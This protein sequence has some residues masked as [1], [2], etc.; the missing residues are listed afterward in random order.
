MDTK[1]MTGA[2]MF[3]RLLGSM[4][5]EKIFASSGSEWSP[6]WE[7]LAKPP[8]AP[9]SIPAYLS[10]RHEETAVGM[11]SGYAKST[12][13]L[14]AVMI[15]TTVGTLHCAMALRGA[16]HDNIPMVVFAGESIGFG[17]DQGP[18]PGPQWLRS[19]ADIGGPA[20]LIAPCVK[21]SFGINTKS[22]LPSTIQR[23]CQLAMTPPFGPVFVSVPMEYLFDLMP[24]SAPSAAGIPVRAT[25]DPAGIAQLAD[26]LVAAKHPVIVSERTGKTR[27]A[28]NCLVEL[29]QTLGAPVVQTRNPGYLNFPH[30]HPLHAGF[31][32]L[33]VLKDADMIFMPATVAPWHP[34][35]AAPFNNA[36]VAL[37]DE[38]PLRIELPVWGYRADLCLL[39]EV[40]ASLQAL[41]EQV[42]KRVGAVDPVRLKRSEGWGEK[43]AARRKAWAE[44]TLSLKD[45]KPMATRWIA[46][47]LNALL[48]A[49]A[50]VVDETITHRMDIL[51]ELDRLGPGGFFAGSIGGLGTGLGTALGVKAAHPDKTVITTIGDG[52]FNYNPVLA[53]LG[54]AQEYRMPIM[55]VLFDNQGYLSQQ[56]EIPKYYPGGFAVK[57]QKYAGTSIKPTPEYAGLAP[58]FGGYGERVDEPGQVRAALQRGLK[59]VK[60]GKF[61]LLDVRLAPVP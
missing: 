1:A 16:L 27:A 45:S 11:A 19:L 13:K 61:A 60:E 48:P 33:P 28:V 30:D 54:F 47:E 3:L 42:R 15:H 9:G 14:P 46:H 20:R 29:A 36:K 58:L 34:A 51:N 40:E 44:K 59:A 22:A 52:S 25:A 49:D 55:I 26:M 23:A 35:S 39:G 2:E 37:L 32:P 57:A 8:P 38:N 4:G 5:V 53:S 12:S 6:V 17:E 31:E 56:A 21:W 41:L 43:N 10:S 24:T 50:V 7:Y 18:D